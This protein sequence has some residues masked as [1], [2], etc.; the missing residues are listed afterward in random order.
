MNQIFLFCRLAI[1]PKLGCRVHFPSD[2]IRETW[3]NLVAAS[4]PG[5][6]AAAC[7]PWRHALSLSPSRSDVDLYALASLASL[8]HNS[9]YSCTAELNARTPEPL[10][11]VLCCNA[12][13][14][15][16]KERKMKM[17][18]LSVY[19]LCECESKVSFCGWYFQ[20]YVFLSFSG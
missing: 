11:N 8:I 1:D 3:V 13:Q 10:H 5:Y 14:C 6:L 18:I 2:V 9:D 15:L 4:Q 12:I 19:Q 7:C 17:R 20:I 16:W